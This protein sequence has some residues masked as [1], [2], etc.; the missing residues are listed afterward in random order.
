MEDWVIV[1]IVLSF[2]LLVFVVVAAI[3]KYKTKHRSGSAD[4]LVSG[5]SGA[6]AD[7]AAYILPIGV[8]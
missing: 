3:A 4:P 1:V 5:S 6:T 7:S 8:Y 2:L